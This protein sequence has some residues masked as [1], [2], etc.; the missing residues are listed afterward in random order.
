MTICPHS[1]TLHW[2]HHLLVSLNKASGTARD[3]KGKTSTAPKVGQ[4]MR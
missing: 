1:E 4:T 2:K 3:N